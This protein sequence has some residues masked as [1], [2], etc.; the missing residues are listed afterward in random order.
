MSNLV[1]IEQMLIDWLNSRDYGVTA[2]ADVP[3]PRPESFITVER[4]GGEDTQGF[5][6]NPDVAVQFWAK[7]RYEAAALAAEVDSDIRRNLVDGSVIT[8]CSRNSLTNFPS[9]EN[10]PRYQA[11]YNITMYG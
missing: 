6:D 4:T 11:V 8:K 10:E 2:Y 5:L 3:N 1:L 7:S 9:A